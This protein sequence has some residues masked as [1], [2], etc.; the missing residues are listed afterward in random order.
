M[1][2]R[3]PGAFEAW[4]GAGRE[5]G[6]GPRRS[7]ER[8]GSVGSATPCKG[9]QGC[10]VMA[11]RVSLFCFSFGTNIAHLVCSGGVGIG[12]GGNAGGCPLAEAGPDTA[13]EAGPSPSY[14]HEGKAGRMEGWG[15]ALRPLP[16]YFSGKQEAESGEVL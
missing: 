5:A 12:A 9:E 15:M 14:E 2:G 4:A 16:F 8:R 3:Q 6:E 13:E 1:G 11:A 7:S 10:G